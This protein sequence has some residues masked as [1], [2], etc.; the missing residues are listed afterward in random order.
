ML[1]TQTAQTQDEQALK[2]ALRKELI[3]SKDA[4]TSVMKAMQ[5]GTDLAKTPWQIMVLNSQFSDQQVTA[6]IGIFF[7]SLNGGCN[8]SDDLDPISTENEYGEF[9]LTIDRRTYDAILKQ[10]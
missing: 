5:H 4:L 9:V 7:Q 1:L 10:K 2:L 8:C 6:E 3:A